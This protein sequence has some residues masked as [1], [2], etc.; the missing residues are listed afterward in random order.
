MFD[1]SNK[2]ALL[3]T[4]FAAFAIM[5]LISAIAAPDPA[6][7]AGDPCEVFEIVQNMQCHQLY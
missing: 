2:K 1:I 6:T 7:G 5:P 3:Q 4:F